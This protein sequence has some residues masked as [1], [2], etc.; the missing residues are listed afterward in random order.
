ME[1]NLCHIYY[2]ANNWVFS[3][4]TTIPENQQNKIILSGEYLKKSWMA[5]EKTEKECG[6]LRTST[7]DSNLTIWSCAYI[8]K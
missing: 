8:V 7:S 1:R 4:K 6:S 2:L 3:K 5:K